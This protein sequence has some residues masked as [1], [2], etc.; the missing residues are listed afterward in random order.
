MKTD[1]NELIQKIESK[2]AEKTP[3][4]IAIDGRAASGKTSLASLLSSRFSAK[5][6]HMD[7]F[8]LP[9]DL[10]TVQRLQET[11]G[12]IHY[13]RFRTQVVDHLGEDTI[14]FRK[15]DCAQM[16]ETDEVRIEDYVALIIEGSYALHPYFGHYFDVSVF[17][18][19]DPEKQS[20]RITRRN[21][22][23]MALRFEN[24]W[25]PKEN[26]YFDAFEIKKKAD[27]VIEYD[28]VE[29]NIQ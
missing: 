19:I 21:G 16:K 13:E 26:L 2:I 12:N 10:R 9:T 3:L 27:Y 20:Q 1:L 17:V 15:F 18:E 7:D 25:I 23:K 14:H 24:E 29:E 11:G 5:V 4:I 6:I 22:S 28:G 8:F